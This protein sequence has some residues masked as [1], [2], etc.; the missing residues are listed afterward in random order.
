MSDIYGQTYSTPFAQFDP[1][2]QSWRTSAVTSLWAL[3]MSS[4]TL[5]KSGC[6]HN[7]ELFERPMLAL[8]TAENAF[9]SLP[10]PT[11]RDHKDESLGPR[12]Q[13]G[14]G[15]GALPQMIAESFLPTPT[16][17]D[18]LK[19]SSNL[20]TSQRRRDKGNQVSFTDL[21]QTEMLPP[22]Q[23]HWLLPTPAVMDM[24]SNYTP[25]EWQAWKGKQRAAHNNGNGHGASLTQEALT[26]LPTPLTSDGNPPAS[27]YGQE[28]RLQLRDINALL[29]TPA[30]NDMGAG[31]DPQAWNEWAA[32]QKA[33]DGRPAP[34][35]KSLEQ[36]ALAMLPT[37]LANMGNLQR[38]DFT[39][40]LR[41]VI[42]NN[43]MLPTPTAQAAKHLMDDRGEG[44][45]DDCNLWSVVGRLIGESM[46]QQSD[47]GK[48]F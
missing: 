9:S 38:D 10:T 4:L 26:M 31:K 44:T 27:D 45:P 33:A 15:H 14:R 25:E 34:H 46:G 29:P 41:T 40:N 13:S 42:E 5:P 24:G 36:E 28:D 32:R 1:D 6:L 7:G 18:G 39:P 47:D 19:M 37:P 21:V 8:P 35:G 20:A 43:A 48:L 17:A 2:T 12:M 11:A 16:T 23:E 22:G 30:V 3:P